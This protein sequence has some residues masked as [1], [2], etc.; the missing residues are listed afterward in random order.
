[1]KK[2]LL[3][4]G[5]LLFVSGSISAQKQYNYLKGQ[6]SPFNG[7]FN[8]PRYID[9]DSISY[10][11]ETYSQLVLPEG[12]KKVQLEEA[13]TL[14]KSSSDGL[15]DTLKY[16]YI[17]SETMKDAM[18]KY[19]E[20]YSDDGKLVFSSW[21]MD[22]SKPL[23]GM[24]ERKYLYDTENRISEITTIN[25]NDGAATV[26]VY[27]TIKFDYEFKPYLGIETLE[28]NT[29]YMKSSKAAQ[30][31]SLF[32]FYTEEGYEIIDESGS[33]YDY[34]TTQYRFDAQNRLISI[35]TS[36]NDPQPTSRY[37]FYMK[38]DFLIEYKYTKNGYEEFLNEAKI[39]E[40]KFQDDGY[41]ME[42]N[43]YEV[44][45]VAVYPPISNLKSVEKFSY[46]KNGEVISDNEF[47]G[48]VTPKIYGIQ[49]GIVVSAEK[50]LPVSIYT[51]SGGLVKQDRVSAGTNTIP[52][53]KGLYIV[54][55]G[56]MSYKI[57]VQ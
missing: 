32:V 48:N 29:I 8:E 23:Y 9:V 4:F 38:K 12:S 33:I 2:L 41:C 7:E 10:S 50:S 55:I 25:N 11:C 57:L 28:Y 14:I 16:Y 43:H 53:T 30:N 39:A 6:E 24:G 44:S 18:D 35:N 51:F 54:V 3:S 34:K 5:L 40:Y 19:V 56:N 52:M 20:K 46:F 42:I 15:T 21:D 13:Y 37:E 26:V 36:Y 31:D 17:N 22:I 47:F 1:M 49:G 45:D 27:D